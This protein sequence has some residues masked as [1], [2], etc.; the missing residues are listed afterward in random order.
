MAY[1][2]NELEKEALKVI[3]D[4]KLTFFDDLACFM[5]PALRTLYTHE[6]HEMHSIKDELKKN[7]LKIK[8]TMRKSWE[9]SDN[10]TLQVSAYKLLSTPDELARLNRQDIKH[11]GEVKHEITGM[12]IK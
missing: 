4:E 9:E 10:A 11:S 8:N 1:E 6:L 7:K 3:K 2:T 12:E 5:S